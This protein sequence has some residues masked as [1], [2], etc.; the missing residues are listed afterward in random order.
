MRRLPAAAFAALVVATIAA[1]FITQHLK[2]STPVIGP[3]VRAPEPF[4]DDGDG[5]RDSTSINFY[6]LHRSDKVTVFIVDSDGDIVQTVASGVEMHKPTA[7]NDKVRR[8]FKWNGGE[9]DG[10]LAPDGSYYFRV[11]LAEQGRIV[12]LTQYPISVDNVPPD[13]VVTGVSS[14]QLPAPGG[15][16]ASTLP[17]PEEFSRGR[18]TRQ[19]HASVWDARADLIR[20]APTHSAGARSRA[21]RP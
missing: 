15:A 4:S 3:N 8:T 16:P 11:A 12:N 19:P 1:F 14:S 7:R 20:R 10:Q 21:L 17:G 13:L 9:S 5:C 2:S 6:V 18:G